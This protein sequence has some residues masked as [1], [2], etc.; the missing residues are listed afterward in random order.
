VSKRNGI[1][2][3]RQRLHVTGQLSII[4]FCRRTHQPN[5]LYLKQSSSLSEQ[6][7]I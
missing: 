7:A 4:F 6:V 3:L 1:S 2:D 5:A